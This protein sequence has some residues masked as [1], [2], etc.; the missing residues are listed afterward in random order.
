[1]TIHHKIEKESTP[2]PVN[3]EVEVAPIKNIT[4]DGY[5]IE[6]SQIFMLEN[7]MGPQILTLFYWLA[8][9]MF[10]FSGIWVMAL[11][12]FPFGLFIIIFGAMISRLTVEMMRSL[13]KTNELLEEIRDQNKILIDGD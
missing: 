2:N 1:M 10:F 7:Q 9:F 8:L 6:W 4:W 11:M 3:A 12:N 13:F 5:K